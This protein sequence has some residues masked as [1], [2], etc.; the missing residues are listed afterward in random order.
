MKPIG[1][2]L[3]NLP[4]YAGAT[5]MGDGRVALI[6]DVPGITQALDIG[7]SAVDAADA[8]ADSDPDATALLV[9]EVAGGRRAAL[10]LAAVARLEEFPAERVERSGTAEVVQYRD[11]LLPLVR[12]APAIGL[13][14]TAS[15]SRTDGQVSV[16]VHEVAEGG[17]HHAVGIVIDRVVD[18]V[19]TV[20][21]RSEVGSRAGVIGSAVVQDKVTDL[22]DLDVVI[23]RSGVVA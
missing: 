12:L 11:G 3:K 23:A 13:A 7:A 8:R 19:E 21:V 15:T 16:V 20:A 1:R 5:I 22:V 10:P 2:Q 6:L 14:D 18:V 17:Q 4:M 9:L